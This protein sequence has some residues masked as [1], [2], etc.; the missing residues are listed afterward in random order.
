MPELLPLTV[1]SRAGAVFLPL[2]LL[3]CT[4]A[5]PPTAETQPP[6][7]D[8]HLQALQV[9]VEHI[10]SPR[11]TVDPRPFEL[12]TAAQALRMPR[13][14]LT[15]EERVAERQALLRQLGVASTAFFP[16][17]NCP[18]ERL[19]SA[20]NSLDLSG[21]PEQRV[22]KAIFGVASFDEAAGEWTV[23]AVSA[24]YSPQGSGGMRIYDIIL[25][26]DGRDLRVDRL[27]TKIVF[28]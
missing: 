3:G 16:H 13:Y 22:E 27:V 8:P 15:D 14:S 23:P 25:V 2:C 26:S 12:P 10:A 11:L 24:Y 19:A 9:A 21:C 5:S 18:T 7:T 28:D 17:L 6:T 1:I 20:L 4:T